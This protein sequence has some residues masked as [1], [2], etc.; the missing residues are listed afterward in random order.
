MVFIYINILRPESRHL[1]IKH[2]K[3]DERFKVEF[4]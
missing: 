4:V 3:T 1:L 2:S